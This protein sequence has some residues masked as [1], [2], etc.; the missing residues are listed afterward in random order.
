MASG[1]EQYREKFRPGQD[2]ALDAEVD[3]ALEGMSLDQLMDSPPA[4]ASKASGKGP[5]RGRIISVDRDKGEVFIDFGGKSQGV[6]SLEQFEEV[7]VVGSEAEF[8]VERFDPREGLLIVNRKGAAATNVT[9]ETLELGQI[10]EGVVTGVN[11]GGLEL[12]VRGMR[13]FMPAGQV[14]VVFHQ[15]LSVF[16]NQKLTAEVTQFDAAARNLLLSRRNILEREK[17]EKRAKTLS[18]LQ[19]GQ[20]RRGVVRSVMDF[21]AFV[22][23]DGADGLLHVSELTH[24]RGV[25]TGDF[26]KVGDVV[27]VKVIR[28]DR[29]TGRIGLSLKQ[30]MADPWSTAESRYAPGTTVTGRVTRVESFGAFVEIEDGVEGLLPVSE[31]SWQRVKH[32]SEVVQPGDTVRLV[33]LQL[34]PAK[35]R[36]SFSL[37]QAGP[38]PWAD[39]GERYQPEMVVDGVVSRV[40]DFGAFVQIEPGLEGL[41]HLSELAAQR[42]RTPPEVVRPGQDVKVRVLEVDAEGRRISLSIRRA[43]DAAPQAT[44]AAAAPVGKKKRPALRGGLDY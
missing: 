8:H 4:E 44:P 20:T 34:D 38:N 10:V 11:K 21:G 27:D 35:K 37:R 25:K 5:R 13:A 33:V 12:N 32:P 16:V 26:V 40:V 17:E 3:A 31:M 29:E 24:R 41:V 2:A 22:D 18:E 36:L 19:E 28:I 39:V 15:D 23:L 9:W 43:G 1:K 6:A 14:D 42:V 7:P 30:M